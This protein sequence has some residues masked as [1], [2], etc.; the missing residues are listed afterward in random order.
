MDQD[1]TQ[2]EDDRRD[3][4]PPELEVLASVQEA[5]LM[6]TEGNVSDGQISSTVPS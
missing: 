6:G 1:Q 2:R 3:Y 4:E 5:T